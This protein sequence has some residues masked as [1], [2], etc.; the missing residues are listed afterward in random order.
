MKTPAQ[1][2]AEAFVE[3]LI[4]KKQPLEGFRF[5]TFE[6]PHTGKRWLMVERGNQRSKSH[7]LFSQSYIAHEGDTLA[8]F[9]SA[10]AVAVMQA[11]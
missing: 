10:V 3:M 9:Q 7:P 8:A 6:S 11:Q 4:E 5:K 2:N 1:K